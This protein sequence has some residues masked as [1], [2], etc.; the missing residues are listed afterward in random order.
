VTKIYN[1]T[2]IIN[3]YT[4]QNNIIVNQGIDVRRVSEATH[5]TERKIALRDVRAGEEMPRGGTTAVYRHELGAPVRSGPVVAQRVDEWHPVIEHNTLAA[6]HVEHRVTPVNTVQQ[7]AQVMPQR[8]QQQR[9]VPQRDNHAIP[10]PQPQ[11]GNQR[12]TPPNQTQSPPQNQERRSSASYETTAPRT[13]APKQMMPQTVQ[14]QRDVPQR[15]NH[16]M[17]QPQPQPGNQRYT[18]PNQTQLPPQNQDRRTGN[19]IGAT[20]PNA[21]VPNQPMQH[22]VPEQYYTPVPSVAQRQAV[23]PQTRVEQPNLVTHDYIPR[24]SRLANEAH[25]LPPANQPAP[26][27]HSAPAPAQSEPHYQQ[28]NSGGNVNSSGNGH[29]SGG[30]VNSG[31]NGNNGGNNNSP[32]GRNDHGGR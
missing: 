17:P 10:H 9:D 21:A 29:N 13:E 3:N 11:P 32:G 12:Y 2:T 27:Y 14:Q 24:S 19:S 20:V 4:V 23:A 18:P 7:P 22:V 30:N 31:G 5:T 26:V 25:A 1:R 6:V 16:S 28:G 15:D 8:L